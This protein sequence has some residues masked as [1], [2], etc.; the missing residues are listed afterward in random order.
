MVDHRQYSVILLKTAVLADRYVTHHKL[1]VLSDNKL[2]RSG[3]IIYAAA[4]NKDNILRKYGEKQVNNE[5]LT[6]Q[7]MLRQKV[8]VAHG[9]GGYRHC[10]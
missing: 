1:K 5:P 8:Y 2:G 3:C 9:V 7:S 4:P 10:T 6:Q